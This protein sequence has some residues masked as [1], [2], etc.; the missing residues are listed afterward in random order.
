MFL[1]DSVLY[2]VVRSLCL[3]LEL[4]VASNVNFSFY[5]SN[6]C[7][8]FRKFYIILVVE[9]EDKKPQPRETT[10]NKNTMDKETLK[11]R[12]QNTCSWIIP[13]YL[14]RPTDLRLKRCR[15]IVKKL[16]EMNTRYLDD[17]HSSWT[18]LFLTDSQLFN[19]SLTTKHNTVGMDLDTSFSLRH[20]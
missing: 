17:N 3:L 6:H 18:M 11:T 13:L 14:V 15:S 9:R 19:I 20:I 4:Y 16:T 12:I 7:K 5:I 2:D 8:L 10:M 1:L